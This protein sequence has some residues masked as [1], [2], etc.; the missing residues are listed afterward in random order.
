MKILVCVKQV[1]DTM[2]IQLD[3]QHSLVRAGVRHILNPADEAAVGFALAFKAEHQAQVTALTMG[4]PEAEPMLR[5][6]AARGADRLI[7]LSD[8]AFAGADTLATARTLYAAQRKAGPFDLILCG[9]RAADGETGQVGPAL[10]ALMDIPV[11]TEATSIAMKEDEVEVAQLQE[12][13]SVLWR[14]PTPLLATCCAWSR[15]MPL[16]T[17]AGLRRAR[18]AVVER[19]DREALE[20]PVEACGLRGSP[21]RVVRAYPAGDGERHCTYTTVSALLEEG[22]LR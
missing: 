5:D 9:R 10:G 14:A 19:W 12:Q 7:L 4:R 15:T 16:P 3:A 2:D 21:T 8:A 1:P 18:E 20:L 11:V 17:I 13:A 22:V 6:L